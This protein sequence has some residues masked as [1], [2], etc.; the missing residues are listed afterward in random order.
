MLNGNNNDVL[1]VVLQR[2]ARVRGQV[3]RL[4]LLQGRGAARLL[5]RPRPQL[6]PR[7]RARLTPRPHLG[8][9]A[10]GGG[11]AAPSVVAVGGHLLLVQA[12]RFA[13]LG[14]PVLE[15]D[16]QKNI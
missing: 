3:L 1:T 16:L 2:A 11:G 4:G 6:R 12:L 14:A 8:L 10:G 15:P 13:E 5:V 9:D 7:P